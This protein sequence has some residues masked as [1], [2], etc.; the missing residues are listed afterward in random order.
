MNNVTMK[1]IFGEIEC[2]LRSDRPVLVLKEV[3]APS[4]LSRQNLY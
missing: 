4:F 3:V 2:K 1:I